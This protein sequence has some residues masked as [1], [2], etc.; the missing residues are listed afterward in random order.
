MIFL[1]KTG[2]QHSWSIIRVAKIK[3]H[4]WKGT[5]SNIMALISTQKV[6][7]ISKLHWAEFLANKCDNIEL[8]E[9]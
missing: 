7:I 6:I 5:V 8:Y 3:N 4:Y 2:H 1:E 9:N